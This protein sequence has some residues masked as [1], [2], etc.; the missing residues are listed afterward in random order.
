MSYNRN[1]K[2]IR[3]TIKWETFYKLEI[4]R[5]GYVHSPLQAELVTYD[6]YDVNTQICWSY[7]CISLKG[8]FSHDIMTTGIYI[9]FNKTATQ[10]AEEFSMEQFASKDSF[11]AFGKPSAYY[12]PK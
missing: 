2:F 11:S 5:Q 6:I 7:I 1:S 8:N 10:L 12:Y 9:H 3:K 4:M